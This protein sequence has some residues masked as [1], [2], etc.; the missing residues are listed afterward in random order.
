[1]CTLF[2]VQDDK[3]QYN[4]FHLG[5]MSKEDDT[6]SWSKLIKNHQK[7]PNFR[8]RTC[9]IYNRRSK[10]PLNRPKQTCPCGRLIDRHSLDSAC[11]ESEALEKGEAWIPPTEFLDNESDSSEVMVNIFGTLKPHGCKFLRID[12]RLKTINLSALYQ[13]ILEDCDGIKPGLI[14]N[15][16]GGAK[17][18]SLREHLQTEVVKD[19]IDIGAKAGN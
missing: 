11:L 13:L 4:F 15:I 10:Q 8:S 16:S 9:H 18:F 12:N 3:L 5:R 19:I 1:M 6:S 2:I 17:Y 7:D 14:I